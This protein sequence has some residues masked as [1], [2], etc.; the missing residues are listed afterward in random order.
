[1]SKKQDGLKKIKRY[2]DELSSGKD[3][4]RAAIAVK[5]DTK[6]GKAPKIIA[7]GKGNVADKILEVAEENKIPF[8]EDPSLTD[9]LSKLELNQQ[10]PGELYVLIAEVLAFVYQLDKLAKKRK[11]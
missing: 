2:K 8:F 10:I 7:T 4:Q 9:L 11:K 5:Y 3:S 1:M 6:E